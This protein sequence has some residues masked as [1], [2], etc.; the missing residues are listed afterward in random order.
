[1]NPDGSDSKTLVT[2][3]R[4]PDGI[5]LDLKKGHLYW[6][7]MGVPI[8]MMGKSSAPISMAVTARQSFPRASHTRR[9]R[10]ISIAR[11]ASLLVGSRRQCASCASDLD[12]SH[13]ETLV[14]AGRGDAD[15]SDPSNWCVGITVDADRGHIY[16]TQKGPDNGERGRIFRANLDILRPERCQ[17]PGYYRLVDGLPEPIT[18]SSTWKNRHLYWTIAAIRARQTL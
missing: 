3:C 8:A 16:W 5:A 7:D 15:R 12:G 6:T 17:P 14:E 11:I 18:W 10:S 1:M 4:M 2:G 13:I 9:S